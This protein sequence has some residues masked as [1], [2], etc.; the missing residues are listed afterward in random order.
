MYL[1][2]KHVELV[3]QQDC[4]QSYPLHNHVSVYVIGIVLNGCIE[5]QH[6][7]DFCRYRPWDFFVI[8][9]YEP[10]T[11]KPAKGCRY[12]LLSVC[13]HK[14]WA[15]Q[16][17]VKALQH[18]VWQLVSGFMKDNGIQPFSAEVVQNAIRQLGYMRQKGE[19][20]H[21]FVMRMAQWIET[22]ISEADGLSDDHQCHLLKQPYRIRAFKQH[23]GLTP[24]QFL[25]QNRIRQ[26][27][28]LM[29]ED[30]PLT[31]IAAACG[32][33]DQSHFIKIFKQWFGLTPSAYMASIRYLNMPA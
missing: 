17:P 8:L 7:V 32:F 30:M 33:Y 4:C 13:L 14:Q 15:D 6:A 12:D 25:I 21:P 22:H 26:A 23:M 9:P 31:D 20:F 18:I 3:Y 24:H 27:Q 16:Y 11:L 28:R 1:R 10:H 2:S 19:N 29:D 5:M